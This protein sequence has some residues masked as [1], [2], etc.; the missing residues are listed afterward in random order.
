MR[1]FSI[2][3]VTVVLQAV[4]MSYTIAEEPPKLTPEESTI[5]SKQ[6]QQYCSLCHGSERQGHVND[7]AP[8]LKSQSLLESGFRELG[9]TIAYGRAGT[10]MAGYFEEIGGPLNREEVWRLV[11]WLE[12][13]ENF[14]PV[15]LAHNTIDG[16]L[17]T[18]QTLYDQEC[19]TCHGDKGEGIN[20]PALGNSAMLSMTSDDFIKHAIENGRQGT[21]MPAFSAKLSADDI[22]DLTAF[23]RSRA[24]GWE[25]QK[26]VFREP[27]AA[28]EYVLNPD[29]DSPQIELQ[30]GLYVS[31]FALNDAL[32]N[33]R[34]L[35]LLDTRGMSSWQMAN[36]EGSVPLPYY[37]EDTESL[38]KDLPRDGTWIVI[39]CNC[40][41]AAA[42]HVN[43][44]LVDLGF[45]NTAVLWEGFSG[46]ASLG[47]PISLGK[48]TITNMDAIEKL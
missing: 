13:Q 28:S 1:F 23:I 30:D 44:K 11:V 12:E 36:I 33:K 46:W 39:Y 4:F 19:S 41:R 42:E 8:S 27:P 35:V 24:T 10:P 9:L 16:D 20:G 21:D 34:K 5:A 18:G 2:V 7:H 31:S 15:E 45:K 17:S 6:Y 25:V 47:F 22:N 29:G 48:T 32:Q 26:P 43:N 3:L 37:Y 40:P 38:A 14:D